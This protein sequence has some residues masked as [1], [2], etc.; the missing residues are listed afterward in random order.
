MTDYQSKEQATAQVR[1]YDGTLHHYDSVKQAHHNWA[2]KGSVSKISVYYGEN[3]PRFRRK[4]KGELW[5]SLSEQK[6]CALSEKY[7]NAGKHEIFW[8]DQLVMP[9]GDWDY[10]RLYTDPQYDNEYMAACIRKVLTEE[11]FFV[12]CTQWS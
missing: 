12:F 3:C 9:V 7:K 6:L 1:E 2:H 8:I 4:I 5:N 11:E 10:P